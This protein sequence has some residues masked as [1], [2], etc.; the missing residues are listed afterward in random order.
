MRKEDE[1]LSVE[2]LEQID[3]VS[4]EPLS[5]VATDILRSYARAHKKPLFALLH[6]TSANPLLTINSRLLN[7]PPLLGNWEEYLLQWEWS[8]G[9]LYSSIPTACIL[10]C[11]SASDRNPNS[12]SSNRGGTAS[13]QIFLIW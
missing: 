4:V 1:L 6:D 10:R 7:E 9:N 2:Q 12:A 11:G 5:L 8:A 3:P 13:G